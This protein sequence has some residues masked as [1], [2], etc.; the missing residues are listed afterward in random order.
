MK[1]FAIII[2]ATICYFLNRFKDR[3]Y[4]ESKKLKVNFNRRYSHGIILGLI[5]GL[6]GGYKSVFYPNFDKDYDL[7]LISWMI[8]YLIVDE[9][10]DY[11]FRNGKGKWFLESRLQ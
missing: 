3:K 7:F 4:P 11:L 9:T 5:F 6:A 1:I 10:I 2:F 8:V